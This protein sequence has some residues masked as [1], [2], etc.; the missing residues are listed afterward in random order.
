MRNI[1]FERYRFNRR[2]QE[3]GESYDHYRTALRKLAEGCEFQE[4]TPDE[5]LRD[6]LVFGIRDGKTRER[7]LREHALTLKRTD[8]ICHAAE[9]IVTQLKAFEDSQ[10]SNVSAVSQSAEANTSLPLPTKNLPDCHNCGRK[11]EFQ[12]RELCPAFR[13]ICRKCQKPNHF[14]IR[15]RSQKGKSTVRAVKENYSQ[16]TENTAEIFPLQLSVHALDDSQFVTLRLESGSHIRFQVDTGAQ[17]NVILLNTYKKATGD[18]SL[19]KVTLVHTQIRAYGGG[20]LPVVRMRVWQGNSKYCLEYQLVNGSG[21]RP[22][23]GRKACLG[24]KIIAYLDNDELFKPV[25]GDA[26]VYAPG[27]VSIEHLLNNHPEVF[28]PCMGRT[29]TPST[30]PSAA[31]TNT[32]S[33]HPKE[34]PR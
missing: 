1:P 3:A 9:S 31:C 29:G 24:M 4:T 12:R 23:L 7:L 22:L 2:C 34:D 19:E 28:G 20:T 25:T 8:E 26:P 21:I 13:K 6:R 30:A 10:G 18:V 32:T 15:C 33:R 17:C 14:A 16:D 11:H 27:P 5:I